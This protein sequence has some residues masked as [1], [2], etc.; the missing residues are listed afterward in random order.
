[1]KVQLKIKHE[2]EM[3]PVYA[4]NHDELFEEFVKLTEREISS[5]DMKKLSNRVFRNVFR[6]KKKELLKT[7]KN[8]KKAAN[9]LREKKILYDMFHHI[10]R[11]YRWAC[12]SG[13][14][15]EIEIKVWI[16]SSIDKIEMILKVLE[17]NI[18]RD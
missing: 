8:I 5:L 4:K 15:R 3:T 16:A 13:S 10:F 9:T 14:E 1:M 6:K 18:E 2:I 11:N 17:K 7:R 12:E